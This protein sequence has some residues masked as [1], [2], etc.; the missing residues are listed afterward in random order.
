V[1]PVSQSSFG[2]FL[3]VSFG[4]AAMG[5]QSAF[6]RL[7]MPAVGSTNVMTTNTSQVAV[8]ATQTIATWIRARSGDEELVQRYKTA[9]WRF[10]RSVPLPLAFLAGTM[11]GAFGFIA[12]GAWALVLP[13]GV[14]G[15]LAFRASKVS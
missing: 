13:I 14:V 11:V 4:L 5:V 10:V 6:V 3:A 7:L 12:I 15:T 2:T 9:S 8:D 1:P